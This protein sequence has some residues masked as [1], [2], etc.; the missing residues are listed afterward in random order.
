[1]LIGHGAIILDSADL[2]IVVTYSFEPCMVN[3]LKNICSAEEFN[4][5]N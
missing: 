3:E 5:Y 4:Q 1:M 2:T